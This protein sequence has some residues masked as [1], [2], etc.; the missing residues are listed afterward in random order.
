MGELQGDIKH[1]LTAILAVD[2][3]TRIDLLS[4][5][6]LEWVGPDRQCS[7]RICT[8]HSHPSAITRGRK[9]VK[10]RLAQ[11]QGRVGTTISPSR[12][13]TQDRSWICLPLAEANANLFGNLKCLLTSLRA[14]LHNHDQLTACSNKHET[15]G[16]VLP[17][18]RRRC[19]RPGAARRSSFSVCWLSASGTS[20]TQCLSFTPARLT[21]VFVCK[22][23]SE[24]MRASLWIQV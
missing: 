17:S 24:Q 14:L 22:A 23:R 5:L 16:F 19:D 18:H 20:N 9:R 21:G 11:K 10:V 2:F 6:Q 7:L 3:A 15:A 12:G 1:L 13:Y 8:E 4:A